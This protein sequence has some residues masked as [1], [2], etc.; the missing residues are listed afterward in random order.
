MKIF[1]HFLLVIT[2]VVV[3]FTSCSKD[4][5]IG[6]AG[7]AGTTG[8]TGAVGATGADGTKIYS[9]TVVPAAT[10]GAN[11]DFY[12][13]TATSMLYGPKTAAGWG[14]AKSLIGATGATGTTGATGATG[15]TGVAGSKILSGTGVPAASVGSNGDYYL[16]PSN[17]L[18]YGPKA[19]G[20]WPVPINLKGAKGDPGTANVIY[21]DWITPST[22]TK[23]TVFGT[24]YFTADIAA[25][26]VTQAILDQGTVIVYG[27]LDGYISSIWPTDQVANLPI[28]ITYMSGTTPNID[29]WSALSTVGSI[30]ISMTSSINA[31]GAISNAH[32]FRYVIIPG[33]VHTLS[34]V[35]SK[36][37]GEVKQVLHLRD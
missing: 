24:I 32:Q 11:G 8:A 23:A 21:S 12:L 20:A 22:Y 13:N 37:Y 4:G 2:A 17:Y 10:L 16:D 3:V 9:G 7:P 5:P 35:N 1:N 33:G 31:Y 19:N 25:S 30:R 28:S 14:T 6:P 15:A 18:F 27:K 26:K 34:S 29:V 36:N